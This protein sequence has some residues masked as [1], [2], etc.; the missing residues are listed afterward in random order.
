MIDQRDDK[1]HHGRKQGRSSG[2]P[3]QAIDEIEGVGN[4]E[5]P[6]YRERQ[7]DEPGQGVGK[8]QRQIE[9]AHSACEE[10]G[11]GNRLHAKLQV[12]TCAVDII[13]DAETK[14]QAGRN[15]NT[16]K[17]SG[18]ESID[19][20]GKYKGK[21]QPYGQA[22]RESQENCYASQAG[23]RDLVNMP[24]VSRYGNPASAD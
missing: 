24:S 12:W 23:K 2:Q 1:K 4:R 9:N 5:H 6:Q 15:I 10:H 14:N 22:D 3:I 8:D 18:G 13:V 17:R 19:Q 20:P 21:P 16:E 11:A 7:P